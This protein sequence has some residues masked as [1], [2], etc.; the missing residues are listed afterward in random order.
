[1]S[2]YT[3]GP[4]KVR[5]TKF[6]EVIAENGALICK[7]QRLTSLSNLQANAA[8]IAQAPDLLRIASRLAELSDGL[9]NSNSSAE[10]A[11]SR[12][13]EEA[14]TIVAKATAHQQ[15]NRRE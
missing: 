8:L 12:L 10:E 6:S 3:K 5:F 7:V 4:W 15:A 11:A 9:N 14:K 1:M 2:E 13:A